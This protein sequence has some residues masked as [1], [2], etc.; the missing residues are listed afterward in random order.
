MICSL[1]ADPESAVCEHLAN[2]CEQTVCLISNERA[3][4]LTLLPQSTLYLFEK[5]AAKP[6]FLPIDQIE[7]LLRR[8]IPTSSSPSSALQELS[9][10]DK[11]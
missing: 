2:I 5:E 4:E 1:V 6:P 10:S 7:P 11:S 3:K 9:A 8:L